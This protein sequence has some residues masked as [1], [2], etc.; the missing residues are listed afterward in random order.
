[1]SDGSPT[2][3]AWQAR[4]AGKQMKGRFC[5]DCGGA[6]FFD[7]RGGER[8]PSCPACGFERVRHPTVGV[9]IVV[10]DDAGR[11]LMGRRAHGTYAGLWCIPCGRLE[12]DEDVRAGAERELLEETGLIARTGEVFAVR[13]N[14]HQPERQTVGIWFHGEVVGGALHPADGEFTE[15]GY[16]APGDPPPLAFPTDALVLADLAI[17][18]EPRNE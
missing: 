12:W 13:S 11:V 18:W 16:F 1:M 15:V 14:F 10:I 8:P 6:L 17:R 4:I 5:P 7:Y 2:R 9:A 3:T